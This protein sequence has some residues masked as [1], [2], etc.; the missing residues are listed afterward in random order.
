M[1]NVLLY[2]LTS[3]IWGSTWLAIKFQLGTV[4]PE[5]SIVYRFALAAAL[6]IG[7]SLIRR[8]P[9]RFSSR[10]HLFIAL[11]G[12]TLFSLNYIMVYIAELHITSGLVAIVFSLII[13]FNVALAGIFLRDPIRPRVVIGG[14]FGIAGLAMVFWPELST[15][16]L[17]GNRAL[18]LGLSLIG[19]LSASI[20]N[21]V[22]AR[23]Q[24]NGLPIVQTNAYGMA[25]GAGFTLLVALV[26]G[27]EFGFEPT[28]SYIVSLG[29]LALFGSV[30]AFGA[31]L[32]ILSRI[33]PDRAAYITVIFPIVALILSTLFEGLRWEL[34]A[35]LG[36]S[37]VVVGNAIALTRRRAPVGTTELSEAA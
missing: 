32:T 30:I 12:L 27:A 7:Y 19:T 33:G 22:A 2:T 26:R 37:L 16:D 3:L 4:D 11:Q 24:R 17:S 35:G 10:Q 14:I 8:L 36:V 6:L 1:R 34:T 23:N 9:M 15:L 29:Y 28:V 21:I 31:Y 20:G 25:Y 18:G 13:V 5:M